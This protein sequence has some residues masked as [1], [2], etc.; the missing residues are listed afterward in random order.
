[1]LYLTF[2][3][4]RAYCEYLKSKRITETHFDM[5]FSTS[6]VDGAI[7]YSAVATE[8]IGTQCHSQPTLVTCREIIVTEE[9]KEMNALQEQLAEADNPRALK[10]YKRKLRKHLEQVENEVWRL[11]SQREK[12]ITAEELRIVRGI[13]TTE[14]PSYLNT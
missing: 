9:P 12:A 10:A 2:T 4:L 13:L 5:A 3:N 11:F 1:M 8:F 7:T 6:N 14:T